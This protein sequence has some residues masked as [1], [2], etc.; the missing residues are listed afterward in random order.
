MYVT[1]TMDPGWDNDVLNPAFHSIT[2]DDF[3]VIELGW[4]PF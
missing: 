1:G 3:E 4:R 2:A